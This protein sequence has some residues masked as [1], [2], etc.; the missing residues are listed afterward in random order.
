M[1]REKNKYQRLIDDLKLKNK[2]NDEQLKKTH[3][4]LYQLRD[5]L[6]FEF[7]AQKTIQVE[8]KEKSE[9]RAVDFGRRIRV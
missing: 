9:R 1:F 3:P 5:D 7:A 4:K 2:I 8:M 6:N